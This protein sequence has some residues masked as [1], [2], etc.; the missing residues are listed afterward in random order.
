MSI[1][2]AAH[3]TDLYSCCS[4]HWVP[5]TCSYQLPAMPP[6][7]LNCRRN[8]RVT[9]WSIKLQHEGRKLYMPPLMHG[10]S[11]VAAVLS[12][13]AW[14]GTRLAQRGACPAA[15]PGLAAFQPDWVLTPE[16]PEFCITARAARLLPIHSCSTPRLPLCAN[17]VLAGR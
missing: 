1:K 5:P 11:L 15:H 12:T 3:V 4:F 2:Y 8:P 14:A 10:E 17:W 13:D 9:P 7:Y 6:C 16:K